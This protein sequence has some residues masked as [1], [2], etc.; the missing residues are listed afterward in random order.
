MLLLVDA[1]D[2]GANVLRQVGVH[3]IEM[4]SDERIAT[5]LEDR[6]TPAQTAMLNKAL[7]K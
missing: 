3:P 6:I 4:Y 1:T 7:K 5:F 2:D